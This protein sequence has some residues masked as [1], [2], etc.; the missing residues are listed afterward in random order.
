VTVS[1][2]RRPRDPAP[3]AAWP[4]WGCG[5]S[6]QQNCRK[7][8]NRTT[9]ARCRSCLQRSSYV[10]VRNSFV[11]NAHDGRS[12]ATSPMYLNR[13]RR[14]TNWRPFKLIQLQE[15][16][17]RLRTGQRFSYGFGEVFTPPEN[18]MSNWL[19]TLPVFWMAILVFGLT[20]LVTAGIYAAIMVFGVGEQARSFKAISPGLL[21]PLGYHLRPFRCVHR[22][23]GLDRQ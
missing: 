18:D 20:Y 11:A 21:S 6:R 22:L 12:A 14:A 10:S 19:H 15:S 16:G 13:R 2:A 1:G 4:R 9:Q 5:R 7:S 17:V 23:L 3:P 8:Q